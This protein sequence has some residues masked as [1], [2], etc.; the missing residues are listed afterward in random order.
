[1][2]STYL[3]CHKNRIKRFLLSESNKCDC[4]QA[5]PGKIT[6]FML[7]SGIVIGLLRSDLFQNP[8]ANTT[9]KDLKPQSVLSRKKRHTDKVI[10]SAGRTAFC[11]IPA[12]RVLLGNNF[13]DFFFVSRPE[14]RDHNLKQHDEKVS[15][16]NL[17]SKQYFKASRRVSTTVNLM[18]SWSTYI[19]LYETCT[20]PC[21]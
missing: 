16:L 17:I 10:D 7:L 15:L 20:F 1:M 11:I 12:P 18:A 13:W 6:T 14:P 2:S 5:E 8:V 21:S 4:K 9:A 19:F 3:R